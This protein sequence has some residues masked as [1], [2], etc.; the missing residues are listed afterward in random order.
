MHYLGI[1]NPLVTSSHLEESHMR[2]LLV[3]FGLTCAVL[4]LANGANLA[5][6]KKGEKKEV[7]LKGL[8]C[9]PKCELSIAKA[10]A[11]LVQLKEKDKDKATLY[12]FDAESN[13]KYHDDICSGGKEGTV[14]GFVKEVEKKKVISVTKVEYK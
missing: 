13:K 4:L 7:V 3:V 14:T 10:C 1:A 6:D 2:T 9:C 11:T 8:I 5:Q 12:Y